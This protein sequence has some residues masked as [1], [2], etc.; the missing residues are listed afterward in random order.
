[1]IY[2]GENVLVIGYKIED[3][4]RILL[5]RQVLLTF[6][7][8]LCNMSA[9]KVITRK[10]SIIGTSYG[11]STNQPIISIFKKKSFLKESCE[12]QKIDYI[13]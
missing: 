5:N 8:V 9:F 12:C 1:M 4:C 2:H 3:R 13:H 11:N 10:T 6:E 7:Y